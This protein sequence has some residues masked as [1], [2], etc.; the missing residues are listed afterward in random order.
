MWKPSLLLLGQMAPK[1]ARGPVK[2]SVA[3][4]AAAAAAA[5]ASALAG[6]PDDDMVDD[7]G[8]IAEVQH[9]QQL[10]QEGDCALV[11]RVEHFVPVRFRT[12]LGHRFDG[13]EH[14]MEGIA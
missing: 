7:E 10:I 3:T 8:D 6:L 14:A 5:A 11:P 12:S 9:I 1:K 4:A 2:T 13:C